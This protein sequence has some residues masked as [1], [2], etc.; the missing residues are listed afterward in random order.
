[1]SDFAPSPGAAA[2]TKSTAEQKLEQIAAVVAKAPATAATAPGA[3]TAETK[4][5]E[6]S[7]AGAKAE[8]TS[9]EAKQDP[10]KPTQAER[11]PIVE[12]LTRL[13]S[14]SVVLSPRDAGLAR[15][16]DQLAERAA[17]AGVTE[18]AMFRT[19]VAYSLQDV[20]KVVGQGRIDVPQELRAEMTRLAATSPGLTNK[21]MEALLRSTPEIEDRSL[22][23]DLRRAAAN[24]ATMGPDQNAPAV[25]QS[26]EAFEN[27]VRLA[28][29]TASTDAGPTPAATAAPQASR[30]DA[31]SGVTPSQ[32]VR[33]EARVA[34]SP[35]DGGHRQAP[36]DAVEVRGPQ[37]AAV[38]VH[39]SQSK[40]AMAQIMDNLRPGPSPSS[41]PWSPPAVAMGERLSRFQERLDQGKTD[42][43]IRATE[44]SGVAFM[45]AL[46]TFSN[47][48]GAKVLGKIDAA[49]STE[50]GG[51]KTVMQQMQPGG[52]YAELRTQF[53][54]ALQSDRVFAAAYNQVEK[55][56]AQ[57]GRDRLALNADFSAKKL[58][59]KQLD[60]RFQKAEEA[61]GEATERIPGRTPGKSAMDELSEKM[62]ELLNR[63][64]QGV[65]SMFNREATQ[66]QRASPSPGMSP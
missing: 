58:D 50:P 28:P 19:H 4:P 49:A 55:T 48:P 66:E 63:A 31:M 51:I 33:E 64:V 59:A 40:T 36:A 17:M 38:P 39:K 65:R 9:P 42:Q 10:S 37:E 43:I 47:G 30:Q 20:E 6:A 56:G 26:I 24:L 44:K 34:A 23:R 5:E 60:A 29:R 15:G 2:P 8:G 57:Y 52:R 54:N 7:T 25:S 45:N 18:Q 61:I 22:V 16:I 41:P 53:D 3:K 27:R 46:E 12:L 62:A 1:M 21:P 13:Q 35:G 11:D 32:G 14:A